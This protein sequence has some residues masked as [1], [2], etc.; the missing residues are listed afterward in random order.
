VSTEREAGE[1]I[2]EPPLV[3]VVDVARN[4]GQQAVRQRIGG[5]VDEEGDPHGREQVRR[6]PDVDEAFLQ[7]LPG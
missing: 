3:G 6:V 1:K 5:E 2:A 4:V 7:I